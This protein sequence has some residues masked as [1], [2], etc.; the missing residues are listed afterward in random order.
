MTDISEIKG[1][2]IAIIGAGKTG[3]S[4]AKFLTR[5]EAEVLLSDHKSEAELVDNLEEIESLPVKVELE[6]HN[7][8]LSFPT[9]LC[10]FKP[11]CISST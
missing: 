4:L 11:K 2:K 9:G 5:C 10:Y 3:I 7:L 1:R 6:G 8:K